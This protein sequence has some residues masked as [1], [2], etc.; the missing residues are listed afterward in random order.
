MKTPQVVIANAIRVERSVVACSLAARYLRDRFGCEVV[1][2]AD[3]PLRRSRYDTLVM[4][5]SPWGFCDEAHR[6][7]VRELLW[8]A[9]RVVWVQ[10]DYNSGIGPRSFKSMGAWLD[11]EVKNGYGARPS[12]N[13]PKD[14]VRRL[15]LWSSIPAYVERGYITAHIQL[16]KRSRF[17]NWNVLHFDRRRERDWS[18]YP[19]GQG[20]YYFGA[21][22]PDRAARFARYL[23]T[24]S[25]RVEIS[26][27]VGKSAERFRAL[28]PNAVVVGREADISTR[29]SNAT[30]VVVIQDERN[31][32]LYQ[33][34]AARF[35]EALSVG[36]CQLVDAACVPNF[37]RA[38][39]RVDPAWVVRS[40]RDVRRALPCADMTAR[41]QWEAWSTPRIWREFNQQMKGIL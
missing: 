18:Q 6:A 19:R 3:A 7:R 25:Y 13:V 21:F 8:A 37:E 15:E 26:T 2:S 36:C 27:S 23:D 32:A 5:N 11:G 30:A 10:Q 20:V 17:V 1:D 33:P 29:L 28:A 35:Y 4:M 39:F 12:P 31:D 38:G 34:P 16:A 22:R 41:A 14:G 40:A 24:T 9:R